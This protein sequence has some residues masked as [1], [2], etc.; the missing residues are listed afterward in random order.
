MNGKV[1]TAAQIS[2]ARQTI[3]AAGG[4]ADAM[5]DQDVRVAMQQA[6]KKGLSLTKYTQTYLK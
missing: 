4:A 5:S 6:D 3:N 1:I 2:S